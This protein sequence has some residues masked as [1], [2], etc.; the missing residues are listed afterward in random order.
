MKKK[1]L[2]FAVKNAVMKHYHEKG[3]TAT[4]DKMLREIFGEIDKEY[5]K[6]HEREIR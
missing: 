5:N 3:F 4:A 1:K 2:K 6:K